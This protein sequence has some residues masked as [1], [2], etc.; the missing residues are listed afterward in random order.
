MRKRANIQTADQKSP[1]EREKKQ[2]WP[3]VPD[4]FQPRC[5]SIQGTMSQRLHLIFPLYMPHIKEPVRKLYA[6]S[7]DVH[8]QCTVY[9]TFLFTFK[10]SIDYIMGI[11]ML[12][13]FSKALIISKGKIILKVLKQN[14]S[15]L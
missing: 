12:S 6:P 15:M 9:C 13:F 4:V 3:R 2:K 10:Y 7:I 5:F 11:F 1:K 14:P 8:L